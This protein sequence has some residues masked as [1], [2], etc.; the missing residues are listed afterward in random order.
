MVINKQTLHEKWV[1]LKQDIQKVFTRITDDE[2]E[3]TDGNMNS[4][5]TLIKEKYGTDRNQVLL[6]VSDIYSHFDLGPQELKAQ[7]KEPDDGYVPYEKSEL[8]KNKLH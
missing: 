2:L 6:K 5:C 7:K 4:I 8:F 1:L 3:E